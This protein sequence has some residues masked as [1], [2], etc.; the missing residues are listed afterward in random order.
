V[1][2]FYIKNRVFDCAVMSRFD[3]PPLDDDVLAPCL[4]QHEPHD[5]TVRARSAP[6]E[7]DLYHRHHA[8]DRESRQPTPPSPAE[9]LARVVA[10]GTGAMRLTSLEVETLAGWWAEVCASADQRATQA[11][12]RAERRERHRQLVGKRIRR[13]R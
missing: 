1:G 5:I 8:C 3:G 13:V 9:V 7:M 11:Q 4:G 10:K 12:R 2:V 6:S